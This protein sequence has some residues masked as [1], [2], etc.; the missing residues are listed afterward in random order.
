MK[1]AVISYNIITRIA[2]GGWPAILFM[3]WRQNK[4]VCDK[5]FSRQDVSLHYLPAAITPS[6]PP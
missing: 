6:I 2:S 5:K 1:A 4:G 3:L